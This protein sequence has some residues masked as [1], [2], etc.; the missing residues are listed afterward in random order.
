MDP[1]LDGVPD[2]LG[3][4]LKR[5]PVIRQIGHITAIEGRHDWGEPSIVPS[6]AIGQ[7]R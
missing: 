4:P 3:R 6:E 7:I 1:S 5:E 2:L